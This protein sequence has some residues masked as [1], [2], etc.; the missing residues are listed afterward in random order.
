M[1]EEQNKNN[2]PLPNGIM[3]NQTKDVSVNIDLDYE[4]INSSRC[5]K[6]NILFE[7]VLVSNSSRHEG[8]VRIAGKEAPLWKNSLPK[9]R[10]RCIKIL[11]ENL[12]AKLDIHTKR[13]HND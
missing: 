6:C 10:V 5:I 11:D 7:S 12:Q 2:E 13:S 4:I 3:L 1:I 8:I 9:D